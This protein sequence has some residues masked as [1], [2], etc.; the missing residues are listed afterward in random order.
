MSKMGDVELDAKALLATFVSSLW[1]VQ[2]EQK[3]YVSLSHWILG[4]MH[5]LILVLSLVYALGYQ[6]YLSRGYLREETPVMNANGFVRWPGSGLA[7]LS[8]VSEVS[9]CNHSDWTGFL[10]TSY[11]P[12]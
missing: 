10:Y 12:P 1:R 8:P 9:Y 2:F 11:S 6:V 5:W 3:T 4:P 7:D